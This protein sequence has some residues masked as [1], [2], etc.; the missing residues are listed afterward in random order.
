MKYEIDGVELL[1]LNKVIPDSRGFFMEVFKESTWPEIKQSNVSFSKA[2]VVRGLHYQ[3]GEHA[4]GKIVQVLHGKI[5]DVILDIRVG[6]PTFGTLVAIEL[7]PGNGVVKIHPDLAHGFWAV[8][9][10]TV[11]Y[12][13][14]KE[15]A[16]SFEGCIN[17]MSEGLETPWLHETNL[18]ISDK[19]RQ[20]QTWRDYVEECLRNDFANY[21][22]K[23]GLPSED[24]ISHLRTFQKSGDADS[25]T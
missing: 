22:T 9:D 21:C 15:W 4:Q 13:C 16:P 11:M 2:G 3:K 23:R 6:S 19:D 7:T 5:I 20:G 17:P 8:E 10:S 24:I 25:K 12:H 18:I 14:T 1:T